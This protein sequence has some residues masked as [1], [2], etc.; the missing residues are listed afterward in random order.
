M[1]QSLY[2]KNNKVFKKNIRFGKANIFINS[3]ISFDIEQSFWEKFF[4]K[5]NILVKCDNGG[6]ITLRSV[7]NP[8]NIIINLMHHE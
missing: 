3:F 2:Y 6:Q 1:N 8:K 4:N 5:G 7:K